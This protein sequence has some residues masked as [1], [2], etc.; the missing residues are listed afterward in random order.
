MAAHGGFGQTLVQEM[1]QE[2]REQRDDVLA[3]GDVGRLDVPALW[4]V[5]QVRAGLAKSVS[6]V[7]RFEFIPIWGFAVMLLY[8]MRRVQCR[9]C[10]VKVEQVPWAVGKHSLTKAYMFVPGALGAQAVVE[11]Y[12]AEFRHN[13]GPGLPCGGVRRAMGARA[14]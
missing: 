9:L 10:G 13:L 2:R 6:V 8:A 3:D 14:P 1:Q 7:R 4:P 11:G 12:G 5:V